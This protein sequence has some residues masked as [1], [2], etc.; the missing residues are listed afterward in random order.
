MER[1]WRVAALTLVLLAGAAVDTRA[2]PSARP[3]DAT[4]LFELDVPDY[5]GFLE[6]AGLP[7]GLARARSLVDLIRLVHRAPGDYDV[8]ARG[9]RERVL[10]QLKRAEGRPAS[11]IPSPLTPRAWRDLLPVAPTERD[12]LAALLANRDASL[13]YLGLMSTD[14]DTR[15]YL[16]DRRRLLQQ[17]VRT[18]AGAFAAFGDAL[19]IRGGRVQLPGGADAAPLWTALAG[20]EATN[21]ELFVPVLFSLDGGRLA[22]FYRVVASA[23]EPHRRFLLEQPRTSVEQRVEALRATYAVVVASDRAWEPQLRPFSGATSDF[24]SVIQRV[25][26]DASG[27]VIGWPSAAYWDAIF[28]VTEAPPAGVRETITAGWVASRLV[29]G[30]RTSRRDRVESFYFAQRV[31][32]GVDDAAATA[33]EDVLRSFGRYRALYLTLERIGL[34]DPALYRAAAQRAM[35]VRADGSSEAFVEHALFQG[36]L[37][38]VERA[39]FFGT[40]D[41][42]ESEGLVRALLAVEAPQG[43]PYRQP[44]LGW[45]SQRLLATL[46]AKVG[47]DVER[48]DE[49]MLRGLSGAR[50]DASATPVQ[51]EDT[52]YLADPAGAERVRLLRVREQ[53][54]G[55][56]LE[57]VV[58]FSERLAAL[59]AGAQVADSV[60]QNGRALSV[61][62]DDMRR[63]LVGLERDSRHADELRH[64]AEDAQRAL[65]TL[66]REGGGAS[67]GVLRTL[68]RFADRAAADAMLAWVYA[69]ALG[70]PQGA[71]IAGGD[72]SRRHEFG[73]RALGDE[74]RAAGPWTLP[75]EDSNRNRTWRAVGSLL[76]LDLAF[77]RLA[78]RRMDGE[79]PSQPPTLAAYER[80]TMAQANALRNARRL[81]DADR[82]AIA[83]AVR[84]GRA[85]VS[86]LSPEALGRAEDI[87][88]E[89]RMDGWRRSTIQW[90]IRHEPAAVPTLFTITEE[91]WLGRAEGDA[92]LAEWGATAI[93][94]TGCWCLAFPEPRGWGTVTGR[95]GQGLLTTR[96]ADA[97]IVAALALADLHLPA[98]L[99]Q[100]LAAML[101]QTV[102]DFG[103][104]SHLD[105]L[106]SLSTALRSL[107]RADFEDYVASLTFDGPLRP[108]RPP[109][110][111]PEGAR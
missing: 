90:A 65:G 20:V 94:V 29:L 37:A 74:Q 64:D 35:R 13:L 99:G 41:L 17:I 50:V 31:F 15:V 18:S 110:A 14:R 9:T 25:R 6:A 89:L 97:A 88:Q 7:S 68:H 2:Q 85:S 42:A 109:D 75:V 96:Y 34:R 95:P 43:R 103:R 3:N 10:A 82:D 63:E 71:P 12:T 107:T 67:P 44:L 102:I 48:A 58:L 45:L 73:L 23:D 30:D 1:W 108:V 51:F 53:Q 98:T 49:V 77:A 56:R 59:S 32:E 62:M 86:T 33:L 27:R 46:S 100:G 52:S 28:G 57:P 5:P 104:Q 22:Y 78:L 55:I 76:G 92:P 54:A 111:E 105:D 8:A 36:S 101:T 84:R 39:V 66:L 106:V 93:P 47:I 38:L 24:E 70:D 40:I 87:A 60:Q 81:T 61:L 11:S 26:V 16:A 4:D 79:Y 72:V 19:V 21:P 91:Y 69:T 80:L 83:A